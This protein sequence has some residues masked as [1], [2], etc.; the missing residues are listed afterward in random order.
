MKR[1]TRIVR[2]TA[3]RI[4]DMRRRGRVRSDW[5]RSDQMTGAEIEDAIASNRDEAEMVVDWES[6]IVDL[7]RPKSVLNMR[8]D[9]DVLDFFRAQGRGYQTRI[10]AVLRSYVKQ[11]SRGRRRAG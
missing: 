3:E 5:T 8:V 2:A 4:D 1:R 9:S 7:P 10:N 11:A 6:A